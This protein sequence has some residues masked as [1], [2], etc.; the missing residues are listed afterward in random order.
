MTMVLSPRR[1]GRPRGAHLPVI[2][3]TTQQDI[4]RAQPPLYGLL[5]ST[6]RSLW[7]LNKLH[8]A[9]GTHAQKHPVRRGESQLWSEDFSKSVTTWALLSALEVVAM[10]CACYFCIINSFLPFLELDLL[11]LVDTF[12]S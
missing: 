11:L 7:H 3:I 8:H 2:S 5:P 6:S 9:V 1:Y 4:P 12:P 10:L